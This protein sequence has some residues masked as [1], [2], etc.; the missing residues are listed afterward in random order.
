M[1]NTHSTY[2]HPLAFWQVIEFSPHR[3]T[4]ICTYFN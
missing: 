2:F 3:Y 4:S 1:Q